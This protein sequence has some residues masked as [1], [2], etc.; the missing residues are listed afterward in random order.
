LQKYKQFTDAAG[1][2]INART[3]NANENQNTFANRLNLYTGNNARTLSDYLT[4]VTTKRNAELD[5]WNRLQDLN[6]TGA[7]LAG[8]SR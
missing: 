1:M 3:V 7:S 2:D 5:Y 6:Q 4:N 8:G